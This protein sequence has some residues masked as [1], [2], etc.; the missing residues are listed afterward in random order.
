MYRTSKYK[1]S[2]HSPPE[3]RAAYEIMWKHSRARQ[4]TDDNIIRRMRFAF[5]I[6]TDTD[7][8][9]EYA[10]LNFLFHCNNGYGDASHCYV[11][12]HMPV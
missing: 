8:H 6:T 12:Y 1:F 2:F 4:A 11:I 5:W 9:S 10:R 3:I 7:T